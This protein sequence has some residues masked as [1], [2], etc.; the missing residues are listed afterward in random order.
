MP[1]EANHHAPN[2]AIF[3]QQIRAATQDRK[4]QLL[5]GAELQDG[6]QIGFRGRLD[7]EISAPAYSQCG[8]FGQRLI[9]A[10]NR[11]GRKFFREAGEQQFFWHH[12]FFAEFG[13][14]FVRGLGDV[15][16]AEK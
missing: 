14:Q 11:I 15:A 8:A 9:G 6:C 13:G 2:A 12:G 1:G 5:L 4:R 3:D 10:H 7:V 16:G